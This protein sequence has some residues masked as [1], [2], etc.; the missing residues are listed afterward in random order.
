MDRLGAISAF[1][2]VCDAKG[3]AP[4][5]R[6]LRISPSAVTRQVAALEDRLGVRLFQRTTRSVRVTDAGERFLVRA[7]QF[8]ADLNEAEESAQRERAEPQGRLSITAPMLF[9]RMHVAPLLTQFLAR[10]PQIIAELRLSDQN[11]NL[12]EEGHDLAIRIGHLADSQLIARKLGETRRITIASPAF[13]KKFGKPRRPSDLPRFDII[14]FTGLAIAP[15][16]GFFESGMETRIRVAPRY[17]TNS[18]D[19]AI[20]YALAG[21]GILSAFCYQVRDALRRRR[22][23]EIL[24]E[25]APAPVP[26]QAVYPSSRL[27]SAKVRSFI[28]FV[29]ENAKWRAVPGGARSRHP[30]GS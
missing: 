12:I 15:E 26:I 6:R 23:L 18:G 21:G 5:A 19:A 4:A 1:V 16:W 27:L 29:A 14:A 25:F 28:E 11:L 8:L 17:S 20:A 24:P 7:R 2:A 10:H 22:L 30:S 9:G 3:F 13:V